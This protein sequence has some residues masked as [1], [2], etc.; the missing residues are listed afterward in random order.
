MSLIK[1]QNR[2]KHGDIRTR[3]FYHPTS[4]YGINPK[5]LGKQ[6]MVSLFKYEYTHP[7]LPP[8]LFK[9]GDGELWIVPTWQKVVKGTTLKDINW[10]KPKIKEVPTEE[11]TWKFNSSSS[12]KVY[13]TRLRAGKLTCNCPGFWRSAGNCTHVKQVRNEKGKN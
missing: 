5:G 8:T 7:V 6:V 4:N 11:N 12:D 1:F 2:N 3:I 13:I 9:D 10:N